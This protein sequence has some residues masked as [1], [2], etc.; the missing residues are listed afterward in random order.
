MAGSGFHGLLTEED[1]S[2]NG[3]TENEF[4]AGVMEAG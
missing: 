2:E 1:V 4:Q 3:F